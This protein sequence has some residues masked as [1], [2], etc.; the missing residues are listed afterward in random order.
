[1][2]WVC[3]VCFLELYSIQNGSLT[4]MQCGYETLDIIVHP[5]A[6]EWGP[7]FILMV[8]NDQLRRDRGVIGF[9]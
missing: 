4:D 6:G 9:L 2:G 7:E 8:D 1:M 5:F 3:N